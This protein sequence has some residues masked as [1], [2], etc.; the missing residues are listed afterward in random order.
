MTRPSPIQTLAAL[1]DLTPRRIRQL[2]AEGIIP[3]SYELAPSVK[4][5]CRHLE[6]LG[7]RNTGG[8][9]GHR[10]RLMRAQ[11]DRAEAEVAR[12]DRELISA[13]DARI[14][15]RAMRE[16]ATEAFD[17]FGETIAPALAGMN[18]AQRK[19]AID[20]RV[21]EVLAAVAAAEFTFAP[22]PASPSSSHPKGN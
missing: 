19:V 7:R 9:I 12:L 10:A 16:L 5:Y 8:I 6:A 15:A 21:D 3:R 14:I 17:G 2:A 4:S 11:A 22:P 20:T 18:T 1:F 13:S